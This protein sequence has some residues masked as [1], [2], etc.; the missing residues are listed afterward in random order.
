MRFTILLFTLLITTLCGCGKQGKTSDIASYKYSSKVRLSPELEKRVGSWI[1]EGIY[2]YGILTVETEKD[3]PTKLA[4]SIR[5]KVLVINADEIKVKA[6]ET[7]SLAPKAFCTKFGLDKGDTWW[8][9]DAQLFQTR[10]E[11]DEYIKTGLM[12]NKGEATTTFTVD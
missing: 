8:E 10:E 12:I 7:V 9:K 1:Y 11:A 4:K 5:V 6:N 3:I 2:C